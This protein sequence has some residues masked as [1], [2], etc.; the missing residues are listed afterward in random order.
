MKSNP[1]VLMLL[2]RQVL[3]F[4]VVVIALTA[5]SFFFGGQ[6]GPWQWWMGVALACALPFL[7]G[8]SWKDA[9]KTDVLFAGLLIALTCLSPMMLDRVR[10]IDYAS[11]HLPMIRYLIEG[12]NPVSDPTAAGISQQLGLELGGMNYLHVAFL[13][14][15][16]A[17]FAAV[18]HS[19]VWDPLALTYPVTFFLFVGLA[20]ELYRVWKGALWICGLTFYMLIWHFFDPNLYVDSAVLLSAAGLITT[21]YAGLRDKEIRFIPLATFTFW[22]MNVKMPS[23]VGAFVFW[24]VFG[25]AIL[26]QNKCQCRKLSAKFLALGLVLG[27]LFVIVSF[28]PYGTSFRD[29]GHP[30]YPFRTA[31]ADKFPEVNLTWDFKIGNDDWKQMSFAG[32]FVNAYVSPSLARAYYNYKLNRKDFAPH[33]YYWDCSY[34]D[35]GT[36]SPLTWKR[37]LTLALTMALL[38]MIPG[39][40]PFAMMLVVP[41]FLFPKEYVGYL[42]YWAWIDVFR[43]LAVAGLLMQIV[44]KWPRTGSVFPCCGFAAV[45]VSIVCLIMVRVDTMTRKQFEKEQLPCLCYPG[46]SVPCGNKT[47]ESFIKHPECGYGD[48]VRS[49]GENNLILLMSAMGFAAKDILPTGPVPNIPLRNSSLGYFVA[50]KESPFDFDE[51]RVDHLRDVKRLLLNPKYWLKGLFFVYPRELVKKYAF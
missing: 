30:L 23:A 5:A 41:L 13:P 11:Y 16:A 49:Y 34:K 45:V 4:P 32:L 7:S 25:G 46:H 35:I 33:Q 8:V 21:M 31:N 20:L 15:T 40:R 29:Y 42:R 10:Y 28:N 26:W 19:F 17:I 43:A 18:A 24:C 47:V 22:M 44:K 38:M 6:C 14:K 1:N 36:R 48:T 50:K 9:F 12:W 3:L 51:C 37:R 39:F 2:E 27:A